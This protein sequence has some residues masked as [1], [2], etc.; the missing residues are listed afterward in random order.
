[1]IRSDRPGNKEYIEQ[2][3]RGS[4]VIIDIRLW[5]QPM[6]IVELLWSLDRIKYGD[7]IIESCGCIILKYEMA[8]LE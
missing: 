2:R 5:N 1:M 3:P 8:T 7:R 6:M 4:I